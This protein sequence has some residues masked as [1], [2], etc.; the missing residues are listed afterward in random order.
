MTEG[1][2]DCQDYGGLL[3]LTNVQHESR[4]AFASILYVICSKCSLRN[5]VYTSKAHREGTNMNRSEPI[6]IVNSKFALDEKFTMFSLFTYIFTSI[7]SKSYASKQTVT[8]IGVSGLALKHLEFSF[9]RS[10]FEGLWY[11]LFEL[12]SLEKPTVKRSKMIAENIAAYIEKQNI[13]VK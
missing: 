8:K 6:Y 12:N 13:N 1:L 5:K 11:L 4:G 10:G 9:K 2:K 3:D 7:S